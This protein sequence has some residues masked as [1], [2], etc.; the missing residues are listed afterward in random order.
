MESDDSTD[1]Y[2]TWARVY[3]AE[4]T[5]TRD[6]SYYVDRAV[7]VGGRVLEVGC[8]TG[9]IYLEL[10]RAGVDADGIDLSM[11]MLDQLRE[12]AAADGLDPNVWQ[13]DMRDFTVSDPY[14]L[15][16]VP[17]R[18]FLHNLTIDDQL[19]ALR[20]LLD[21][22]ADDGELVLNFYA[23]DCEFVVENYGTEEVEAVEIDGEQYRV[24][25]RAD[26]EDEVA[27]IVRGE[28]VLFDEND[29]VVVSESYR[30]KSVTKREFELLLR[31]VGASSWEVTNFDGD[32][33]TSVTDELVWSISP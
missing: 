10:L 25:H 6:V 23:P 16:I 4:G 33:P 22:T 17:F 7:D 9:R 8:G 19:S 24:L 30:L 2:D 18:A 29:D 12:N 14:D 28:K 20:S 26:F 31:L 32:P 27:G 13:A 11:G 21:A 1:Y 15:V 5:P 3:D